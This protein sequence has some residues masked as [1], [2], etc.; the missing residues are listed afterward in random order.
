MPFRSQ[1]QRRKL[2]A[3]NPKVARQ[4]AA[5]TPK[6]AKLPER[7]HPESDKKRRRRAAL[8]KRASA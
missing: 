6:G 1:A 2:Y 4:F 8:K 7:L 3:T 5:E